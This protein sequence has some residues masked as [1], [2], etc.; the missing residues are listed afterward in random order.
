VSGITGILHFSSELLG[1]EIIR[2][3]TS[4][5]CHRG[6]DGEGYSVSGSTALGH[7]RLSVVHGAEDEQPVYN[8]SKGI[9]IVFD[10]AIYN[11]RELKKDLISGGHRFHANSDAE[12]IVHLY[13]QRDVKCLDKLDGVFAFAIWDKPK[14]RLFLARDRLGVKPLYYYLGD[15]DLI[16]AS[17]IKAILANEVVER[18]IDMRGLIN[19]FTF[20]HSIAPDTIYENIKK[21]LPGHYLVCEN[22]KVTSKQYWDIP[23][24]EEKKDRSEIY[25]SERVLELLSQA[26]KK[27]LISDI[28]LGALLSGG[29]DSST[30][31]GLMSRFSNEAVKT[32]SVGFAT[33]SSTYSELD[34][35]KI[36]AE[37]FET[38]HYSLVMNEKDLVAILQKL[39]YH[40]DEPFGDIA[41]LPTYLIAEFA[42]KHVQVV[43]TGEGGDEL[44][45]G[46]RRYSA[47][48]FSQYY[49]ILPAFLR[50]GMIKK[51]VNSLPR[52]RRLKTAFNTMGMTDPAKRYGNWLVAFSDEMKAHLFK[53]Q[54]SRII[55]ELDTFQS[56]KR[57]YPTSDRLPVLDRI[58][59]VDQKISVPD[60]YL[61][62]TD[63]SCMAVGL[64]PRVPF[65]DHELV[66]FAATIPLEYKIRGFTNKYILKQAMKN[67]LPARPLRKRKHGFAVPTDPWF[68]GELKAFVREVLFDPRTQSRGF[69]NF[70]YIER[71]YKEHEQGRQVYDTQLWLLLVFE[72]WYRCFME[73]DPSQA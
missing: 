17:E 37:H 36:I 10:G 30:I 40:F 35:A 43:L 41:A 57:Y 67:L 27:R 24:V 8:E 53:S 56:Y 7:R 46:Y 52:L 58:M 45:G 26:V 55:E 73:S 1:D 44:F 3:M 13:E 64:E 6:P 62:K 23:L 54:I 22:S 25:Y 48:R 28:P 16:F 68:R 60:T 14:Q 50:D 21:L 9:V 65:L 15:T 61:E 72:L 18:K 31:V 32:F 38:D 29:L 19:Y 5:L 47:E 63:K 20:G 49:R 34:D 4:R 70:D 69:F 59:Y 42:R 12:L 39:V 71:L 66:E 33:E 51:M 11:F 2:N